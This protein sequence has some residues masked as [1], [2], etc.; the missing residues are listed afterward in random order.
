[1]NK[2]KFMFLIIIILSSSCSVNEPIIYS[3]EPLGY[4]SVGVPAKTL[5]EFET[6]LERIRSE[7]KIPGFSATITKGG[8]IVWAKGF[9]YSNK[10]KAIQ[11]KPETVYHLASLTKPFAATIIMQLIEQNKLTLE[12]QVSDYGINLESQGVIRIKHLLSH[13]SEGVPGTNY[14]YNG[15]R[16]SYLDKVITGTS[17]KS[18]CELLNEK[19]IVPLQLSM[20]APNPLSPDDCLRNIQILG[21]LAQGYSSNGQNILSYQSYFSTAAGLL[22]SVIDIA[23]FSIAL[24]KNLLMKAE[25]RELMFTPTVSNSGVELPYGLGWFIDKN[26]S[27]MVIWHYGFWDACSTLI[28]KIPDREISFVILANSDRLSSASQRLGSDENVNRSVVAQEF[29]NA[30]LYGTAQLPDTPIY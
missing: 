5:A 6:V 30:F 16:F 19:I 9:G 17:G 3:D 21:Q 11:A 13:T 27:A 20:T 12:T 29:L 8:K 28:I 18:F 1:M 22:S 14:N 10:E 23:K 25:S 26:E 7:L 15:N 4:T 24:D 2:I